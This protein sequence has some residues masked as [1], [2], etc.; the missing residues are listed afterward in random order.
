MTEISLDSIE[1]CPQVEK[2]RTKGI[3]MTM[4]AMDEHN[5]QTRGVVL[6][7]NVCFYLSGFDDHDDHNDQ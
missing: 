2:Q 7:S 6:V 1:A 4:M 3:R 5:K